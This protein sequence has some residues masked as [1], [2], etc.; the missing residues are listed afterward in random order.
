MDSDINKPIFR[1]ISVTIIAPLVVAGT[2]WFFSKVSNCIPASEAQE[3]VNN[4]ALDM[5]ESLNNLEK[6]TN[7]KIGN[8]EIRL[9]AKLNHVESNML[10]RLD[11][12][13]NI[14]IGVI[15]KEQN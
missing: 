2:L 10:T 15:L 4:R 8:L 11:K 6:R 1:I 14:I 7:E 13:E 12:M 9:D 3:I 5:K